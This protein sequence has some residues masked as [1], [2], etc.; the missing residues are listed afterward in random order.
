MPIAFE[1]SFGRPLDDE[2]EE[3]ARV[4]PVEITLGGKLKLRI[5]GRI[6]RIDRIA[7]GKFEILDYKTGGFWRKDW[8]GTFRGGRR[9]QHAL[10]GLAAVEILKAVH[11]DPKVTGGVYYFSSQKGRQE[12]VTIPAPSLQQIAGVL[13]DLRDLIVTGAFVHAPD[14]QDCTFCD[15]AAACGSDVQAHA[16]AKLVDPRLK[17]YERLK[18]HE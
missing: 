12:R 4:E 2:E 11:K 16:A 3:L 17:S 13:S 10:Y 14:D 1:V 18:A 15:F 9:L 7:P 6:D 5:A 8:T